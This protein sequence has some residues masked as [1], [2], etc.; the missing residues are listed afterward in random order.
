VSPKATALAARIVL[1]A[2]GGALFLASAW[3]CDDAYISFRSLDN[4]L[5][6]YGL[7]WNVDERVQPFT[8]PLWLLLHIPLSALTG[9]VFYTTLGLSLAL[10]VAALYRGT[11]LLAGQPPWL[12]ALAA[13]PLLLSQAFRDY[14]TSGLE[15]PLTYLL[16]ALFAVR[17][18]D[19]HAPSPT[20]LAVPAG[21][22]ALNR[23][24]TLLLFAPALVWLAVRARGRV[25]R[26]LLLGFAPLA[27]WEL[28]SLFYYGAPFPNTRYAKLPPNAVPEWHLENGARYVVNLVQEDPASAALLAAALAFGV[29]AA[30]AWAAGRREARPPSGPALLAAGILAYGSYVVAIGG[31]F[32]QGRFFAAPVFAA[33]LLLWSAL[34]GERS[35][36]P[37]RWVAAGL[38]A[39]ALLGVRALA[40]DSRVLDSGSGIR[41]EREFYAANNRLWSAL[42]GNGPNRHLFAAQGAA[43]RAQ[44][45]ALAARDPAQ[46]YV[47]AASSTGMLGYYA[48]PQVVVVDVMG[49]SDPLLARLPVWRPLRMRIGHPRRQLPDG[50]EA[51]LRTGSLAGMHPE[52][53]AYY[54]PLR[55]ITRDPLFD[56][57]RLATILRFQLG[58]FDA[59]LEAWQ[60]RTRFS[61]PGS[62]APP[63]AAAPPFPAPGKRPA[64]RAGP[65]G[66]RPAVRPADRSGR[67]APAPGRFARPGPG[68]GR[69]A[70]GARTPGRGSA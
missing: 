41:D 14:A 12:M 30:V 17:L 49:L 52:L 24:D 51:A 59:H 20:A 18:L 36:L 8:H 15:N 23:L 27:L 16:L 4:L 35:R 69:R 55:R 54:E 3:V 70:P 45:R 19:E 21:L 9:E 34:P 38:A 40:P 64:R 60:A 22:A 6:G 29:G 58:A 11:R 46:R 66:S 33:A 42:A 13:L 10:S 5:H 53:R 68:T 56:A 28:F 2:A 32:M 67:F 47:V 37:E 57:G 50:Y 25:V 63:G 44:A 43:A 62:P 39:L 26:P 1:T 48:G 7:R 65:P 31:D 61:A